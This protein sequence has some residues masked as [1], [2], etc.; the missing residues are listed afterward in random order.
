MC[1][2][3]GDVPLSRGGL[4]LLGGGTGRGSLQSRQ[5]TK[6]FPRSVSAREVGGRSS[7]ETEVGKGE[8]AAKVERG[9]QKPEHALHATVPCPACGGGALPAGPLRQPGKANLRALPFSRRAAWGPWA[10]RWGGRLAP[11]LGGPCA[12]AGTAPA[13]A[14][15]A[16]NSRARCA[17]ACAAAAGL[18]SGLLGQAEKEQPPPPSPP[19]CCSESGPVARRQGRGRV[20]RRRGLGD[21]RGQVTACA[22][23]AAMGP[24]RSAPVPKLAGTRRGRLRSEAGC[25]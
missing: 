11:P 12:A 7:S 3:G 10:G 6:P 18:K 25:R 4:L 23:P 20:P 16:A 8:G 19:S 14:G 22:Q 9:Q 2:R 24:S 1:E 13:A 5:N 15:P 17:A 21:G